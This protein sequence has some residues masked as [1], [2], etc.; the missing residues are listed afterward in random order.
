MKNR[1]EEVLEE[2]ADSSSPKKVLSAAQKDEQVTA[3]ENHLDYLE[4]IYHHKAGDN[5][6]ELWAHS[7]THILRK[8][9]NV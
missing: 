7:L 1:K 5:D 3:I 9:F 4:V 8:N 2:S 6:F